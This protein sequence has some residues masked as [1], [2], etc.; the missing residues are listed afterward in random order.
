MRNHTLLLFCLCLGYGITTPLHADLSIGLA[1]HYQFENNATDDSGNGHHGLEYGSVSYVPG[2][3]GQAA[4]FDGS[5]DYIKVSHSSLIDFGVDETFSISLWFKTIS[6]NTQYL[7]VKRLDPVVGYWVVSPAGVDSPI[8][9]G[10]E[11]AND[12]HAGTI[13]AAPMNDGKW[14]HLVGV[15]SYGDIWALYVDG[16]LVDSVSD[17]IGGLSTQAD[18][19]IGAYDHHGDFIYYRGLLDEVRIYTRALSPAEVRQLQ[20]SDGD[21]VNDD[22]DVCD[23]TG[24]PESVPTV[25]LGTNRFALTDDEDPLDFD[26]VAPPGRGKGP[27]LTFSTTDTAGC[28]CEQIIDA[29][30][31]G[32]G[33]SKFGCSISAM[34]AWVAVVN[35]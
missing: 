16:E 29:L 4:G 12:T 31:L 33:H 11:A 8:S 3:I 14:C 32:R 13:S 10:G 6:T 1:A 24:I 35:P 19:L 22:D 30:G 20:D 34:E 26:T 2:V 28:S 7:L 15:R 25:R 18:L 5:D 17:T 23:L 9:F 27:G 21:G